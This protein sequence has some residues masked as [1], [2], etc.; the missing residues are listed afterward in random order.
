MIDTERRKK[1]AFH[2]RQLSVGQTTND[3]F[4]EKIADDVSFGW[5]PEQYYRSKQ[6]IP[7]DAVIV[8]ILELCWGLY[9]DTKQH[10]LTG[11]YSLSD[12]DMK[13]IARCILFLHSDLEYEWPYINTTFQLSFRDIMAGLITLG[14]T[15]RVKRIRRDL[16]F[17]EYAKLGDYEVWP[18]LR[19]SDYEAQ[20]QK[21]PF[22]NTK[23]A[24]Q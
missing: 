8:P 19:H 20:L 24:A 6:N 2:L 11:P 12:D 7:D 18:F 3:E 17:E 1:L 9:N 4:E 14:Y 15:W 21:Q 10:K 22:L 13:Y 5:L 16:A 23:K